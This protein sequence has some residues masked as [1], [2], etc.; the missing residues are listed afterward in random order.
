LILLIWGSTF[1]APRRARRS[2]RTDAGGAVGRLA[3]DAGTVASGA[4]IKPGECSTAKHE[5]LDAVPSRCA[6]TDAGGAVGREALDA[7][8]VARN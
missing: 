3:L 6:S 8:T 1:V 7:G 4:G 5:A 2:A